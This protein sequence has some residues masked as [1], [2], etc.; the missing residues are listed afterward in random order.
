MMSKEFEMGITLIKRF[1]ESLEEIAGADSESKA[2]EL[3]EVV[4]HPI[5]GAMA[6][7]KNG[8]GPLKDELLEPL[9]VVVAQ[10]RELTDLQALQNAIREV[11]NLANQAEELANQPAQTE[12]SG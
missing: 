11:I 9:G 4:R 7:I 1:S 8:E 10:M 3:I 12:E 6:Q 5:T 2:K